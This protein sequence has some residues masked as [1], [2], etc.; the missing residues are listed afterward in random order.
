M[1]VPRPS[2]FEDGIAVAAVCCCERPGRLCA[3]RLAPP[4]YSA[5]GANALPEIPRESRRF[6]AGWISGTLSAT[7]G[8]LGLGGVICFHFPSLLTSPELRAVYPM[9][10]MRGLLHFVLVAGFVLGCVSVILRRN[11]VLGVSGILLAT[12]AVLFGGSQVPV[13]GPVAGAAYLGLDWFL[14]NIFFLALLFVPLERLFALRREQGIFRDAW[15]LDLTYF[16]VS[17]L[18]VQLTVFLTLMPARTFFAWAVSAD[19]QRAVAGQPGWLQFI[20]VLFVADFSEYWMHRWMHRVPFLWRFHAIHHSIET[21]D[22]LAASR[23]HLVDIVVVRG[24]TFIPLYL[25]GFANG[26]V[27]AYLVFVSFHAIFIHANV[28]F[29]FGWFDWVLATPRFHHWHH[30]AQQ[31]AVDKNFAVHLPLLD[32]IFGTLLLPRGQEWPSVYGLA[33]QRLPQS[34]VKQA[35]YPFVPSRREEETS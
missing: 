28:N 13:E 31:Q 33:G 17:H 30:S 10:F 14:L 12:I 32:R 23:L 25:L 19:L 3:R 11:K 27:F 1:A 4:L 21:M 29:R 7:L 8:A 15:G 6:G 35:V 9:P 16:F 20:E 34:F 22:W 2:C 26:P 24:V 18:L 5:H